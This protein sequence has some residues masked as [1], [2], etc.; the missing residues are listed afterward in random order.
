MIGD[1]GHD[2]DGDDDADANVE[3]EADDVLPQMHT[4]QNSP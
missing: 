4:R 1:N 3:N 2:D